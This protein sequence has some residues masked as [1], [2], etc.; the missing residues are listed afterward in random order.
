MAFGDGFI[1]YIY[2]HKRSQVLFL[3]RVQRGKGRRRRRRR[4]RRRKTTRV[5][6]KQWLKVREL[7]RIGTK[8]LISPL[9]KKRKT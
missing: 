2:K 7:F 6:D 1:P 4:R 3:L 9:G 8:N 5:K